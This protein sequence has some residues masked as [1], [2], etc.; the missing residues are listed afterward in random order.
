MREVEDPKGKSLSLSPHRPTDPDRPHLHT[1]AV[2]RP[3]RPVSTSSRGSRVGTAVTAPWAQKMPGE[4]PVPV[5]VIRRA[6][7]LTTQSDA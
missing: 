6:A 4:T 3:D 5:G 7:A 2:A 1:P